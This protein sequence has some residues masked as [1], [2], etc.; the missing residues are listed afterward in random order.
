MWTEGEISEHDIEFWAS[1]GPVKCMNMK[2]NFKVSQKQYGEVERFCTKALLY[3]WNG[4]RQ[5]MPIYTPPPPRANIPLTRKQA[6]PCPDLPVQFSSPLNVVLLNT[7]IDPVSSV[8]SLQ[9]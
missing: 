5:A 7:N 6:S 9:S 3:R 2:S 8:E 1:E 4:F